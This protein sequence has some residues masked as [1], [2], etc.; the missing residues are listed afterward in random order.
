MFLVDASTTVYFVQHVEKAS[1][2]PLP[3]NPS[4]D[5]RDAC[6]EI[7]DWDSVHER[8]EVPDSVIQV[9]EKEY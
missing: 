9:E 2:C 7:C 4:G 1:T 3:G 6:A 8:I 5:F